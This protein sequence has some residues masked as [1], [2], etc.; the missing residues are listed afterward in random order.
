MSYRFISRDITRASEDPHSVGDTPDV[1]VDHN[2]DATFDI[3]FDAALASSMSILSAIVLGGG[4]I[5]WGVGIGAYALA[6]KSFQRS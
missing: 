5:G 2:H 1:E 3:V 6:R 4:I